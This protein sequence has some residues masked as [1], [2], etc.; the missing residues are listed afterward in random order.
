MNATAHGKLIVLAVHTGASGLIERIGT[1]CELCG[2]YPQIGR[3]GRFLE[4]GECTAAQHV[5]PVKVREEGARD[6]ADRAPLAL[7]G[8]S[9]TDYAGGLRAA[10]D[11]LNP[12]FLRGDKL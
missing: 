10:A 1:R 5:V 2:K 12:S 11:T 8:R 9:F 6:V 7:S 4:D 3:D